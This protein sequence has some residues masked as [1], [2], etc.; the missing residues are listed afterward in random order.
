DALMLAR[1]YR[2]GELRAIWVPDAAHEAMR[3]LVRA[4][5]QAKGDQKRCQQR[6]GGFLLRQERGYCGKP[7]TAKH[8]AWL[9]SLR[10]ELAAHRLMFAEMVRALDEAKARC[11]RLEQHIAELLPQWSL[12]WLVA[13]L[14]CLRGYKLINA[15]SLAAEIGDPRRFHSPRELMG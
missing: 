9:G 4:R 7:W 6:I 10:F 15:V 5:G 3:D 1:L 12:G 13:A 8:R 2:A 11:E 14:Q